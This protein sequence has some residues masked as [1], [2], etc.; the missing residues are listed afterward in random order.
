MVTVSRLMPSSA[1][2]AE[3]VAGAAAAVLVGDVVDVE[4]L[5]L[6]VN[7][8]ERLARVVLGDRVGR[9][10]PAPPARH[11]R[12][13]RPAPPTSVVTPFTSNQRPELVHARPGDA[14]RRHLHVLHVQPGYSVTS[15]LVSSC[16]V[17]GSMSIGWPWCRTVSL[18]V[19]VRRVGGA[20][21]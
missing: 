7:V 16:G 3:D 1:S 5:A 21:G 17:V 9:V 14:H 12:R 18:P 11:R 13:P 4:H 6:A 19:T 10:R 20:G 15:R 2:A 8:G